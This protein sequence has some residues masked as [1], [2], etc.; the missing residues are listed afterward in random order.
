M[1]K[2]SFELVFTEQEQ[3]MLVDYP[4]IT[5]GTV[6]YDET[7]AITRAYAERGNLKLDDDLTE[8]EALDIMQYE[9]HRADLQYKTMK[10]IYFKV[11]G[12]LMVMQ[13][14]ALRR[15]IIRR[16]VNDL[17]TLIIDDIEDEIMNPRQGLA[18]MSF[19]EHIGFI[20]EEEQHLH[21]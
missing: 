5:S 12:D 15:E 4:F 21:F 11:K 3:A 1:E 13:D 6:L 20:L 14:P 19:A 7:L 8:D 9:Q 2:F 16:N 18:L 17:V 10:S